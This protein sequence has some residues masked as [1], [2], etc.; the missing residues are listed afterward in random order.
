MS[1]EWSRVWSWRWRIIAVIV[2]TLVVAYVL[3]AAFA[4]PQVD[5]ARVTRR[6]VVQSVVASGR[7]VT[8]FRVDVG[9]EIVG[10]VAAVPVREGQ[11]VKAGELLIALDASEARAVVKQ[12]EVA[13]AQAQ[14][15]LR[16]LGELQLPVAE[17]GLRQAEATLTNARAQYER[18]QNLFKSGF[19]GKSVVDDAQRALDVAQS[20]VEAARKQVE[21]ARPTGS[22]HAVAQT[23]LEQARATLDA[24]RAK[25]AHTTI[26]A[27]WDGTLIARAVERG[28][29]VQPG[30]SLMVLA[31]TGETQ[32]VL[33]IDER[34]LALIQLGQKALASADAYPGRRF[35]A[36]VTY[37]NPGVDATKGTVEVKLRVPDPPSYLRQDM[38]VSADIEIERHAGV[39]ALPADAVRDATGPAPWVLQV[40]QGSA[41]RQ[42]V[43]LGLRGDGSVEI[44]DG[45]AE[46]DLV[47]PSTAPVRAG[48]RLRPKGSGA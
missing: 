11:T 7:V 40:K 42:P 16:Q 15:R 9:S 38:T 37:I 28:E 1:I 19:V 41:H 26:R 36:E 5:V 18:N 10:V 14:A 12:A 29:V 35:A 30:K 44:L 24:A 17:Q 45:L 21:T 46:G 47:V 25:L 43:K 4:G 27:P 22:D 3:I 13:V 8:P 31:P 6:N 48:D 33:A 2:A 39:L 34:N 20:Q 32:I 23:A